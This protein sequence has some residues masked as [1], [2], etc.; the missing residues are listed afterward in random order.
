MMTAIRLRFM[1][2][3]LRKL[4]DEDVARFPRVSCVARAKPVSRFATGDCG[5]NCDR[6]E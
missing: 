3:L 1:V 4:V 6:N 2:V 5:N